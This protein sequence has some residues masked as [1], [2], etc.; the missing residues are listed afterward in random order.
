MRAGRKSTAVSDQNVEGKQNHSKR[1]VLCPRL[2][3]AQLCCLLCGW[4][5]Q[6]KAEHEYR[7]KPSCR[8]FCC[9]VV[10][11]RT[12]ARLRCVCIQ[13]GAAP[14]PHCAVYAFNLVPLPCRT[15]GVSQQPLATTTL[16]GRHPAAGL[17]AE[18][19]TQVNASNIPND[20]LYS[21]ISRVGEL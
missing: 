6:A 9:C 20:A 14:L 16:T 2:P 3:M 17:V 4:A 1:S 13:P 12:L 19:D 5:I 18:A 8:W 11:P 15:A 21:S 7:S 10:C